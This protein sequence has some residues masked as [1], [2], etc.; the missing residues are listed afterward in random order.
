MHIKS[1]FIEIIYHKSFDIAGRLRLV[2]TYMWIC[3]NFTTAKQSL[4]TV[5][6][7]YKLKVR[8]QC[9]F[10]MK[11]TYSQVILAK[12]AVAVALKICSLIVD[13][14][15]V[16]A[17]VVGLFSLLQRFNHFFHRLFISFVLIHFLCCVLYRRFEINDDQSLFG[18]RF[19]FF[20]V[21]FLLLFLLSFFL[22]R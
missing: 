7:L 6:F 20:I 16:A 5:F 2:L 12:C 13:A 10:V 14:V 22:A 4:L 21:V 18:R 3:M 15:A 11:K 8:H 9:I 17:V 1:T 19:S